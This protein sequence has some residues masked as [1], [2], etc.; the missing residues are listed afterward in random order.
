MKIV[1][2]GYYGVENLGDDYILLSLLQTIEKIQGKKR[3]YI[4]GSGKSYKAF[5]QLFSGISIHY[6]DK[7]NKSFLNKIKRKL[8]PKLIL[9]NADL[10][11]Y[12]GGGLF[13]KDDP[14]YYENV[15]KK[16]KNYR[17]NGT[18]RISIYGVDICDLKEDKSK[19]IWKAI[20]KNVDYISFRN[21]Y[22][23]DK[24]NSALGGGKTTYGPDITFSLETQSEKDN[25]Y[26]VFEKYQLEQDNYI[27]WALTMPWRIEELDD[28][29]I[30][31]RY[32]KHCDTIVKVFNKYAKL[33]YKN[34][35]IPFNHIRDSVIIND[36]TSRLE[37]DVIAIDEY[38]LHLDEKR[39]L[40]KNARACVSMKFHGV[41]FALYF[42]VPVAAV[43]YAPK[44]VNIM[45]ENGLGEY[46][47]K[48]GVRKEQY[49]FDE[50][51]V[52]DGDFD[53][54]CQLAI[55]QN[56][57]DSFKRASTKLRELAKENESKLL[58]IVEKE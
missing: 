50:F 37:G 7:S 14:Q 19:N 54:I 55:E 26:K 10:Y 47:T 45:N 51:D 48:F 27:V 36:V 23:S 42:G 3:V 28:E 21:E 22:S 29:H 8:Y 34:V 25:N 18:K 12:G 1:I 35:F 9:G 30:K 53:R 41:A 5:T 15:L 40:F 46:V 33:G 43:A 58:E 2:E 52:D 6:F 24:V 11:I 16:I 56:D 20:E 57:K 31:S 38:D 4:I 39:L 32:K 49:F 17:K 44:S 13:V